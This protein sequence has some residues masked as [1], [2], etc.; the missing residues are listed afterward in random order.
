MGCRFIITHAGEKSRRKEL[1]FK[2]K[3]LNH[4]ETLATWE[5]YSSLRHNSKLY[6]YRKAHK[7][8]SPKI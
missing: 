1:K 6:K 5:P 2:V 7:M 3:W 4:D 8:K